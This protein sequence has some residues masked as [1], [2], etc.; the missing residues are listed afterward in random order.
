MVI[1]IEKLVFDVSIYDF[2][3][4]YI[5]IQKCIKFGTAKWLNMYLKAEKSPHMTR[6]LNLR[7]AFNDFATSNK[8]LKY[9]FCILCSEMGL[10]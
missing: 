5:Q 2:L 1:C 8:I 3:N 9:T 7:Y 10:Y 6:I 4:S